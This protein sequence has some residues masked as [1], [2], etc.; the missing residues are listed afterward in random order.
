MTRI[1]ALIFLMSIICN[2]FPKWLSALVACSAIFA[3]GLASRQLATQQSAA[4]HSQVERTKITCNDGSNRLQRIWSRLGLKE[5]A[6][7]GGIAVVASLLIENFVIWIVSATYQPGI[8]GSPEP[9]QDNGRIVLER[10]AMKVFHVDAPGMAKGVLQQLRDGLN[11]QWALVSSFG[12]ALV[13]LELQLGQTSKRTLHGIA[14]HALITLASARLIRTVSFV[15]TVLPSQVP[16]CYARRFPPPPDEWREWLMVGF[17]PATKGGCNDLILSG[18]ATITSVLACAFTSAA[19]NTSFSIAVWT[20]IALDYSIEAYQGLH[21]SVDMWLGCIVT[22][23]LWHLTKPLEIV[24]EPEQIQNDNTKKGDAIRQSPLDATIVGM[25]ALPA[26]LVFVFL[27][28]VPKAF[29]NYFLVG[30]TVGAGVLFAR[31]GFTSF[32]QHVL[33]C[34]LCLGLGAYL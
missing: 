18:H 31:C 32:L 33:L 11:V 14:F 12:A 22:C 26:I 34:E 16:N 8:V 4:S 15:L 3:F 10:L 1:I 29:V 30:F 19:S 7:L 9:L 21:Y 2:Q 6:A 13:C 20:L 5:R 27:T 28:V 17:L 23:L 25:Y 24:D